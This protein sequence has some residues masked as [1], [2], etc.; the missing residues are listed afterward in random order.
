MQNL[1]VSK[2]YLFIAKY[3]KLDHYNEVKIKYGLES[4]YHFIT[5]TIGIV[6]ISLILGILKEN[7]QI[8]LF[9]GLLRMFGHGL[10]AKTNIDCWILSIITY[11]LL[12]YSAKYVY[13]Y[14]YV[15][16]SFAIISTFSFIIWSPAD[17]EKK[18]II[19]KKLRLT[20][21][22]RTVVIS[23]IYFIFIIFFY[24]NNIA[25]IMSLSMLLEALL[26]NP[27]IYRIF[28]SRYNNYLYYQ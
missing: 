5:K 28:K 22:L 25:K 23:M 27:V 14:K 18:P 4:L 9:Y 15:L 7:L 21:K 24:H 17:T 2:C 11:V 8:F 16:L 20:L 10:H 19:D 13:F 1:F 12:G 6:F 26:I 3:R